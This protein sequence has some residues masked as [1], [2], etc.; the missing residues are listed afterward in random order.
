MHGADIH[1]AGEPDTQD[2]MRANVNRIRFNTHRDARAA[3]C[4]IMSALALLRA[5]ELAQAV[6]E[7]HQLAHQA[8]LN[9]P[10]GDRP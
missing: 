6:E 1:E 8:W 7:L 3:Y 10:P 2:V 4:A 9:I 5:G